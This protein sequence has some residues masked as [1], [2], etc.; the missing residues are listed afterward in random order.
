MRKEFI[1][2]ITGYPISIDSLH[3]KAHEGALWSVGYS[4]ADIGAA[5]SPND[6]MTLSWKTP[7]DGTQMHMSF[8]ITSAA[9][10]LYKF[11]RG[12]KSGGDNPTG[13]LKVFNVND[14]IKKPS[15]ILDVAGA[16][17]G[18]ISYDA[19]LFVDG[20]ELK[21]EYIGTNGQSIFFTGGTSRG[22]LEHI[23]RPDTEYQLSL[24]NTA[25]VVAS[26]SMNFYFQK[27]KN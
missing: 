4:I 5:T 22:E 12:K 9:G 14:N 8:S 21:S 26:M 2:E 23:L 11:I 3:H 19:A 25:S 27:P 24:F 18:H 10:G 17:A 6:T 15:T 13:T 1:D 16:N 20:V 7:N